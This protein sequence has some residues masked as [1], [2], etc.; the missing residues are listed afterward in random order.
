MATQSSNHWLSVAKAA[1]EHAGFDPKNVQWE[2]VRFLTTSEDYRP[3][4]FPP[5]G[6]W[7]CSGSGLTSDG[8]DCFIIV[9][10]LPVGVPIS[11]Y[12]PEGQEPE[13]VRFRYRVADITFTD[14][15]PKP[16]WWPFE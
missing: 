1:Y 8:K 15:F 6:P 4:V 11:S 14:R 2:R 12:W 10:F 9:A 16:D 3:V 13:D 7:W 5:P